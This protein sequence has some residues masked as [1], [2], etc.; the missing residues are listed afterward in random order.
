M[1]ATTNISLKDATYLRLREI[2]RNLVTDTIS[3]SGEKVLRAVSAYAE[4]EQHVDSVA[5]DIWEK[6]G[7]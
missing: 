3:A 1:T 4:I 7:L 2:C 6:H 5:N